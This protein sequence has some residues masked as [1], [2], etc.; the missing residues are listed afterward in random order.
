M[1]WLALV[2]ALGIPLGFL[3]LARIPLCPATSSPP[4]ASLSVIIPARNEERNLPRLLQSIAFPPQWSAET[5][6][7]DDA[8]TDA[9]SSIARSCG[10]TVL[11]SASLPLGWTGKTWA[12][13]QGASHAHNDFFL[14][15]DADTCLRPSGLL[16]ILSYFTERNAQQPTALSVLPYHQVE[17][18]YEELSLF[19]HLM[20]TIGAGGFGLLGK[21]RLFGQ[22]LLIARPLYQSS[23]GHTAVHAAILENFSLAAHIEH[24][25]GRCIACGGRD[26]LNIRMFPNGFRQLC[27]GWVKAFADGAAACETAVLL[28]SVFWLSAMSAAFA[29]LLMSTAQDRTAFA[30][31]YLI[32]AAQLYWM[33]RQLGSY[34]L[35]T[36]LLYPLPLLFYF[37]LFGRS[38]YLRAFKRKV[39][40]RGRAL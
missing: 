34:R 1:I 40:W 33:A 5:L 30:L 20:M 22:S 25:G 23:G 4:Q 31:L 38:L 3:L 19:F 17:Q 11:A 2:C 6:V 12:C 26:V 27:E 13:T 24:A 36:C 15:L 18:L 7:V 9:T 39:Q 37:V 21:S 35:L 10:A 32:F 8:S 14:F 16:R 29:T 28:A